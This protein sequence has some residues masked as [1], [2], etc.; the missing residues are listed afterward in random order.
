MNNLLFLDEKAGFFGENCEFLP[1]IWAVFDTL[2]VGVGGESVEKNVV[3][4]W[5]R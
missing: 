3:E 1:R 5:L 2:P 4:W